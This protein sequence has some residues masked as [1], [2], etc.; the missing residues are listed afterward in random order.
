VK[1][2]QSHWVSFRF[3]ARSYFC[4]DDCEMGAPVGLPAA[5]APESDPALAG[6]EPL[7][8]SRVTGRTLFESPECPCNMRNVTGYVRNIFSMAEG[9][10]FEPTRACAL[11][12]F[13]T[14]AINHSTTP[15]AS[16]DFARIVP[17]TRRRASGSSAPSLDDKKCAF[18]A[19]LTSPDGGAD[20]PHARQ[21]HMFM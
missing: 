6:L 4:S 5:L 8:F 11:P 17:L 7:R 12:V 13:K 3:V 1:R 15:P 21:P 16:S 2:L 9:V 19:K 10:G 20:P 14:G 18:A